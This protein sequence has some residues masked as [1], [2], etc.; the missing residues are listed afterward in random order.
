VLFQ[1]DEEFQA[2]K[3]PS[4]KKPARIGQRNF[5]VRA[6]AGLKK[7]KGKVH[8]GPRVADSDRRLYSGKEEDLTM[9]HE[10]ENG[11]TN[12]LRNVI[13]VTKHQKREVEKDCPSRIERKNGKQIG[14]GNLPS[15]VGSCGGN[16]WESLRRRNHKGNGNW[17]GGL[18]GRNLH[19]RHDKTC[20][21]AGPTFG[22][23]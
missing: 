1:S 17:N 20:Q 21:V 18:W 5:G 12:G 10:G 14:E 13:Q 16:G 11:Y 23:N 22:N 7:K 9:P 6:L 3:P 8:S 19:P 2:E 4:E 15:G